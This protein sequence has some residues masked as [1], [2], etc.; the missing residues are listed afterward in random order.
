MPNTLPPLPLGEGWGEGQTFRRIQTT[1][2]LTLSQRERGCWCCILPKGEGTLYQLVKGI[3]RS[4][5]RAEGWRSV[6]S[7]WAVELQSVV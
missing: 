4:I 1:L 2:T 7:E 3:T 6:W 5:A